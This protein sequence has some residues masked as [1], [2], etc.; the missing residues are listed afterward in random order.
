M[1]LSDSI[2]VI[3]A[4]N[5]KTT[6]GKL[7]DYI[8]LASIAADRVKYYLGLSTYL[9]TQDYS[10]GSQYSN[11][12]GVLVS[13]PQKI[14]KRNVMAGDDHIQYDW[15]NDS[16]IAA[17]ELTKG[18]AN[19]I[20]MIDADYMVASEQ[21]RSWLYVDDPFL[22]FSNAIDITG[23][24]T[25]NS[26]LFPSNDIQMRWAT[27]I[28][29][30]NS[31]D[32]EVIF[33]TAEMVRDNYDFYAVMLGMPKT[34]FRNDVAFSIACHLHNV[35]T[36]DYQKLW[37]LLPSAYATYSNKRNEWAVTFGNTITLWKYDMHVL[38]KQYAIDFK[39]MDQLRLSNVEA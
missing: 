12:A 5:S 20:L 32:A 4:N 14:T 18:L 11:F 10:V 29:W 13:N 22:I 1:S 16:R 8:Q 30:D 38:N 3:A 21:L 35:P 24:G 17:Y 9:I 37:N 2:C 19:R 33:K 39:L 7:L 26:K 31:I 36:Y 23:T 27:A 25:Y 34:P 6:D 15:I 28:C